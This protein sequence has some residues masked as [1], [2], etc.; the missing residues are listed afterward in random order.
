MKQ[1]KTEKNKLV[2]E[3]FGPM[4]NA[5]FSYRK[6][7]KDV[8]ELW[9]K[10]IDGKISEA[11]FITDGSENSLK[12]GTLFTDNIVGLD[13]KKVKSI[14][15]SE[16]IGQTASDIPVE[17]YE[18]YWECLERVAEEFQVADENTSEPCENKGSACASCS[19]KG[20][21][22][23]AE[24]NEEP[25]MGEGF[26]FSEKNDIKKTIVVLSG[27][28]GVGKS[29]VAVNLASSLASQ[30]LKVGLLDIDL[31]GPSIPTMMKIKNQSI[32][33]D[34]KR[35]IPA[36]FA[37]IKVMSVGFL[38]KNADDALIWRGPMKAGVIEQ[39]LNQ[40]AWGKLDYLVVDSPP[41][42]GD[43]PLSICQAIKTPFAAVIVTTP[44]EVAAA[45]VRKSV[46]FC[47]QLNI[48]VLGVIENMSGFICPECGKRV[49]I[50]S[51]GGGEA[52]AKKYN[53]NFLG[54]IP[55][56]ANVGTASDEG[57]MFVYDYAKTPSGK[58]FGQVLE[59]VLD[60]S[61]NE[62][63]FTTATSGE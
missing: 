21:C 16:I 37:G 33:S 63:G 9:V 3:T 5:D 53:L 48:K 24:N 22:S 47:R 6:T 60:I 42:T 46:N 59:K 32:G 51:S 30:G 8:T 57:N 2:P 55:L 23:Q 58:A 28:G 10:T 7:D 12:A 49:D 29:T 35:M 61:E 15:I 18:P 27:K 56:D 11:S 31:H 38:L 1:D 39:F 25:E 34:G 40:V 26:F 17:T 52:T 36:E 44:Q 19:Q 45:D 20:S 43:E 13:L 41:G 14:N 62:G 54:S 50:F 4:K